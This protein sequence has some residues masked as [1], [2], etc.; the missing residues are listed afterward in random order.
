[1]LGI[2]PFFL[3]PRSILQLQGAV[4]AFVAAA[5]LS[6]VFSLVGAGLLVFRKKLAVPALALVFVLGFGGLAT[7][8]KSP[9]ELSAITLALWFVGVATLVYAITLV[10]R[11]VLK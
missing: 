8:G 6:H 4:L 9:L 2:A 11:G 1:L 7:M 5:A 3:A 10:K